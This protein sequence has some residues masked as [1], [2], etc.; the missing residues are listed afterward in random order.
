MPTTRPKRN[1]TVVVLGVIGMALV[2]VTELLFHGYFDPGLFQIKSVQWSSSKRVV[3]VA[4]RSDHQAL[5]SDVY[6]VLIGDHVFSPTELRHAY[7]SAA[8]IFA[9]DGKC[10]TV[11]WQSPSKLVV[12][13]SDSSISRGDIDTQTNKRD[14][15]AISYVN[16]PNTH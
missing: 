9:A 11:H 6:F 13:C 1:W 14:G 7:H 8:R 3:V 15:V 10:V 16:I 4:E 2:I 5:N 12:T